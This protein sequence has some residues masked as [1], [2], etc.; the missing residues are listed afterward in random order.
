MK[1]E[2]GSRPAHGFQRSS[3]FRCRYLPHPGGAEV[4]QNRIQAG[5][6]DREKYPGWADRFRLSG[7]PPAEIAHHQWPGTPQPRNLRRTNVVGVFPNEASCLRL[8]SAILMEFDEEWQVGRI[9]LTLQEESEPP[10]P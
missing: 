3:P 10:Q 6:L 5:G 4:R 7:Q 2:V 9:Y 8:S 1:A